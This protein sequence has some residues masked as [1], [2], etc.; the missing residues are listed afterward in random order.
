MK[1]IIYIRE[2]ERSRRGALMAFPEG[3][4]T[5]SNAPFRRWQSMM[6]YDKE[7]CA[8]KSRW[9]NAVQMARKILIFQH[10]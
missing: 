10:F 1:K 7:S 6:K 8:L 9:I 4:P 5:G 2:G 3:R